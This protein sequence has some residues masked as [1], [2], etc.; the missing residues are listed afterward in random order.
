MFKERSGS[1][2]GAKV[3]ISVCE[4]VYMGIVARDLDQLQK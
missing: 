2:K 3:G 4:V 1:G